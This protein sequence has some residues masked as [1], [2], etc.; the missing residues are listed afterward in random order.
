MITHRVHLSIP[1]ERYVALYAGKVKFV[2]AVS[3]GGLRV[4]FPGFILNRFVT[5]DGVH[6]VFEFKID[7]LNKLKSVSR[8]N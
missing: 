7:S 1:A 3:E 4:E 8:I 5:H 2:R 6:G